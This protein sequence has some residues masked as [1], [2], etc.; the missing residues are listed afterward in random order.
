MWGNGMAIKFDLPVQR[1]T[2][3]LDRVLRRGTGREIFGRS[4]SLLALE[5]ATAQSDSE[6]ELS[7][8]E[9]WRKRK[10]AGALSAMVIKAVK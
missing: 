5:E 6:G 2:L 1:I 4:S 10:E 3:I 9:S 8:F 7:V